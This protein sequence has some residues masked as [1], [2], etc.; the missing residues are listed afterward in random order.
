MI[1]FQLNAMLKEFNTRFSHN[2]PIPIICVQ[3]TVEDPR[4]KNEYIDHQGVNI[5]R[6]DRTAFRNVVLFVETS[7]KMINAPSTV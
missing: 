2:P 3:S 6:K 7:G 1:Y 4:F 5:H